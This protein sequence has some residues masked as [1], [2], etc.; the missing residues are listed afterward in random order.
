MEPTADDVVVLLLARL[1]AR[2][3]PWGW[4]RI[5]SGERLLRAEPGFRFGRALGSGQSGGFGLRPGFAYSAFLAVFADAASADAF[6]ERSETVA[7]YRRRAIEC[8]VFRLR[9]TSCRGSWGGHSIAVTAQAPERGLVASLT[10]ASIRPS[11]AR[12]FWKWSPPAE[13]SLERAGGCELAVGLGEAPVL[14]Q[15]TF[16]LWRNQAAMDDYARSGAH[17]DAIKAFHGGDFCSESMFVRFVPIDIRG[18]WRG[19]VRG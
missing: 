15:A 17:L 13:S 16:S 18:N 4:W 14:R 1:K 11:R 9:A 3:I 12:D 2:A 8:C 7:A 19:V 5:A 10:R 6:V